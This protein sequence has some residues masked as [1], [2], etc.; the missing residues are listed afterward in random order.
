MSLK[1]VVLSVERSWSNRFLRFIKLFASLKVSTTCL[2]RICQKKVFL[3]Q[4]NSQIWNS[5]IAQL[6]NIWKHN[7]FNPRES[8]L[9]TKSLSWIVL[10]YFAQ[11]VYVSRVDTVCR[12]NAWGY[13][14][15]LPLLFYHSNVSFTPLPRRVCEHINSSLLTKKCKWCW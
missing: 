12:T 4:Q 9:I 15:I 13:A 10:C 14:Q 1:A 5:A 2:I 7:S 6:D 11:T 8:Q 3:R